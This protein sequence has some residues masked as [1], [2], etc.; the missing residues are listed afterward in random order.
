MRR[1]AGRLVNLI[2]EISRNFQN[3][4][5]FSVT[6]LE[7]FVSFHNSHLSLHFVQFQ[8]VPELSEIFQ[9]FFS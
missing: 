1:V 2:S 4:P 7:S 3:L 6:V 8:N 9:T 5:E